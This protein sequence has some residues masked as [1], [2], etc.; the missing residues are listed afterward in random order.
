MAELT[1]F[2]DAASA[3]LDLA[4]R[5]R[6]AWLSTS[7]WSVMLLLCVA[8]AAYASTYLIKLPGNPHFA[9]YIVPLRLHI[10]GGIGAVLAGPWQFSRRLRARALTLHRWLG[11]LYLIEV[12]IGSV[13]GLV[14]SAVSQ[15]GMP[16]HLGFGILDLLWIVSAAQAYR[17]IR[18]GDVDAHRRWMIRNFAL[19]LAAVMLR[20]Y[21]PLMLGALHWSF[22]ASFI[23]VAWLCWVPNAIV[24]EWLI[25]RR[26]YAGDVGA[27]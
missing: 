18:R 22:H 24:A 10:A 8:V 15:E 13:G 3:P 25:R 20:V 1:Q 17:L 9:E 26:P 14:M 6:R 12:L 2:A 27:P 23:A 21:L 7:L 11:R 4:P 16:T 19:T 5:P